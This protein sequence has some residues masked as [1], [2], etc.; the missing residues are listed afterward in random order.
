MKTAAVALAVTVTL[1]GAASGTATAATDGGAQ[2]Q[3]A[4]TYKILKHLDYRGP[5]KASLRLGYYNASTDKGFGWTKVKKK[6]NITKYSAV[7][8]IAK[9]PNREHIGG[10]SYRQTGYAG[11]YRCT[12]GVCR[13]V[14]QYKVLLTVNEKKLRDNQDKGVITQYCVGITRCPN[15]VTKALAKAN[16]RSVAAEGNDK[17][18]A[19]YEPFARSLRAAEVKAGVN[20]KAVPAAR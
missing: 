20:E 16:G 12:N 7:E 1:G 6:H 19:A 3:A 9:S 14:K 15:W 4:P 2:A 11:K 18:A 8:Y 13:L 10:Q 17:Y 5:G